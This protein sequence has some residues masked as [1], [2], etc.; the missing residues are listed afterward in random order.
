MSD[1]ERDYFEQAVLA[2]HLAFPHAARAYLHL[3]SPGMFR[4]P[5][6]RAV[7]EALVRLRERP[8]RW[9]PKED[10]IARR[11]W[12]RVALEMKK[13]GDAHARAALRDGLP[14][15][16]AEG[17]GTPSGLGWHMS[18]L[19]ELARAPRQRQRTPGEEG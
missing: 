6:H 4:N 3:L 10:G 11:W 5:L 13:H 15:R 7:A 8:D 19:H 1:Q 17:I 14:R 16:L 18:R 12:L 2:A 9:P